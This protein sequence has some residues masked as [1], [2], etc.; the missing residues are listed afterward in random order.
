RK[1]FDERRKIHIA[2]AQLADEILTK[3]LITELC[4]DEERPWATFNKGKPIT[5]RQIARILKKYRIFSGDVHASGVHGKGYK[6]ASFE[7]AWERYLPR[8]QNGDVL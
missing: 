7:D 3:A 6:R 1:I 4:A 2:S 8:N 5:D